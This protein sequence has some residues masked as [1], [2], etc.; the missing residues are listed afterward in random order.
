MQ[1]A[2]EVE[3]RTY[4]PRPSVCF[5]V[6]KPRLREVFAADF[7]DRI[8]QHWICLRLE[9]LFE[10]RFVEQGNVSHNCRK[11][12]GTSSAIRSLQRAMEQVSEYYTKQAWVCKIDVQSFF[13][14]ID[15][16][17]LWNKLSAFI[18]E[19]YSGD[20]IDTLLYLTEVTLKHRP[21][22]DCIRKGDLR[23]W[24]DLPRNKSLFHA[25]DGIGMAIGNITS[26][27]QANFYM[28]HY[29]ERIAPLV[30]DLGGRMVQFVDDI[31]FV[32]P[33]K[34]ACL[35]FRRE[36]ERILR[37]ELRL[38]LHPDKFYLQEA[39]KG[40][41]FLG[42][43][44]KPGRRYIANRTLGGLTDAVRQVERLCGCIARDGSGADNLQ[45]LERAV[46]SVNSYLGMAVHTASFNRRR[47]IFERG[48]NRLW[49]FC[50]IIGLRV[51]KI[52][53]QYRLTTHLTQASK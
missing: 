7:R 22:R 1:L 48:A 26:Q 18:R 46:A 21:Q 40:I 14:S 42:Q 38:T 45:A 9:P 32:A 43:V 23:L 6:T 24:D 28:S 41:K 10:R 52:K 44:I 34:D 11:G 16:G 47:R 3:A 49:Q 39:C 17:I 27:L 35:T 30:A 19:R 31:A 51:L 4:K 8:V 53:Q 2:A 50:D 37:E 33:T 29:V 36:S 5:L 13:M 12:F 15:T 25:P 20:D